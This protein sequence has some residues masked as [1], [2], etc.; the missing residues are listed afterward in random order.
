M[1]IDAFSAAWSA[2]GLPET[3]FEAVLLCAPP[4]VAVWR[5]CGPPQ[6][7]VFESRVLQ[8]TARAIESTLSGPAA[9]RLAGGTLSTPTAPSLLEPARGCHRCGL[10]SDSYFCAR[11]S[12]MGR[13]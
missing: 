11:P 6:H 9:R 5:K 2:S 12:P 1:N 10:P 8:T 7:G 4:P 3:R 13:R